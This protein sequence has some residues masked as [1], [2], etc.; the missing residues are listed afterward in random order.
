MLVALAQWS[1]AFESATVL[2]GA[3]AVALRSRITATRRSPA[4]VAAVGDAD[5]VALPVPAFCA[6]ND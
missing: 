2:T 3:R 4:V 6:P 5:S 1:P